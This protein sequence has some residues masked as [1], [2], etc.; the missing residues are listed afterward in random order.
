M[1]LSKAGNSHTRTGAR[2]LAQNYCLLAGLALLLAG[3]FGF[4]ADATFDTSASAT[5]G[6]G[7]NANGQLQ[8]DSFLGFEVNGWHNVVHLLSGLVLLAAANAAPAARITAIAFGAVY[9]LVALIGLIDGNDV[10]GFIP[11]NGADNLL[12]IA[13]AALGI[14]AGLMSP[15]FRGHR[16][17]DAGTGIGTR[18]RA[19]T[20]TTG[21]R[22]RE[23]VAPASGNGSTTGRFDRDGDGTGYAHEGQRDAGAIPSSSRRNK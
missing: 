19:N 11:V 20:T 7:G 3:I 6:E 22:D 8:G 13:L 1:A 17:A 18:D 23:V 16:T 21:T 12:H 5:D 9:G 14:I 4:I 2:S 10:L 15:T